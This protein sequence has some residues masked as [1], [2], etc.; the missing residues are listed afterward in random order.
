MI[1]RLKQ[2]PLVR[3]SRAG[4]Q[5]GAVVFYDDEWGEYRVVPTRNG[6]VQGPQTHYH[7]DDRDD[8]YTTAARMIVEASNK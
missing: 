4:I 5:V 1:K 6:F 7:T 3:T 2:Q 8:A